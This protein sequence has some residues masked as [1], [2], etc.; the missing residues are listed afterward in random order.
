MIILHCT[1]YIFYLTIFLWVIFRW[2]FFET[3]EL[4]K[5]QLSFFF[6]LKVVAGVALTL[7]YTYYY[8]D[9]SKAD[10][11]RYFND[12]KIISQVL[13]QD[14]KCWFKIMSGIGAYDEDAFSYLVHTQY[15]SHTSADAVTDNT[16]IIRI[17]VLL[18][19]FSF[20]NIFIN[21]L[22]FNFFCFVG[23]VALY[24]SL[25]KYFQHEQKLLAITIFL[26]PSV[27]FWSSGL[28]KEALLFS[29]IGLGIYLSTTSAKILSRLAGLFFFTLLLFIKPAVFFSLFLAGGIYFSLRFF[30]QN[31]T[32]FTRSKTKIALLVVWLAVTVAVVLKSSSLCEKLIDKRNEFVQLATD[33]N[34]GSLL[35]TEILSVDCHSLLSVLPSAFVNSILRPFV[36]ES[37]GAFQKIFAVEN[38]LVFLFILFFLIHYFKFPQREKLLLAVFL[39]SFALLN[40]F[41]IGITVPVVGAIVHYRVIATPFLFLGLLCF[42][43]LEKNISKQ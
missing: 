21:T 43:S 34:A 35:N 24:K 15:F 1:L 30:F 39:F 6:L 7:V 10:I 14:V 18:N 33:E 25:V 11:Y 29:A 22:F 12:S 37:G 32:P 41:L 9:N 36:W 40:Y 17:N 3:E 5:I 8:T 27:V 38:A 26:L 19:Y 2:Q 13:F 20:S 16:L 42:V 23:L 28:L 31:E 4:T